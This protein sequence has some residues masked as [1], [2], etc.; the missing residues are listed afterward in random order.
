MNILVAIALI[1]LLFWKL[2]NNYIKRITLD[3]SFKLQD[4]QFKLDVFAIA[5]KV[6]NDNA[7]YRYIN[8]YIGSINSKLDFLNLGMLI[9]YFIRDKRR[10][11]KLPPKPKSAPVSMSKKDLKIYSELI[12]IEKEY[13]TALFTYIVKKSV[14]YKFVVII[15][16]LGIKPIKRFT[17]RLS[18]GLKEYLYCYIEKSLYKPGYSISLSA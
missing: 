13:N 14:V 4:I 15:T 12:K 17:N 1:G 2:K 5:N 18:I 9:I 6:N 8:N 16:Y 7:K 10:E 3:Y 11:S